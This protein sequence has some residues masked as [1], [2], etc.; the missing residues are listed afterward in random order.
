MRQPLWLLRPRLPAG[1]QRRRSD[2]DWRYK[3]KG[4]LAGGQV[5]VNKVVGGG[6]LV[7]GAEVSADLSG[8]TGNLTNLRARGFNGVGDY[9]WLALGEAKLGI[10]HGNW[11]LY[12][13]GGISLGSFTYSSEDCSFTSNNQGW[14]Y[15]AGAA[16]AMSNK[17]SL[18]VD[19]N[20]INF[21]QKQAS[22]G[23]AHSGFGLDQADPRHRPRRLQPH[24]QLDLT[25]WRQIGPGVVTPGPFHFRRPQAREAREPAI[26]PQASALPR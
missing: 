14:A 25:V 16:V 18:F 24:L 8:I 1:L 3:Q 26:V 22:C 9:S 20:H 21:N 6:G 5:G 13:Q 4:W 11:M 10:T 17:N 7:V 19:Y 2:F 23:A 15:G 12:G